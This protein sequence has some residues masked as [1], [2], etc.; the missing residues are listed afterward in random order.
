VSFNPLTALRALRDSPDLSPGEFA[1]MVALVLRSDSGGCMWA[2][3][4]LLAKDCKLSPRSVR[5][6]LQSL[7]AKGLLKRV[8]RPGTSDY[9][10]LDLR[11]LT[12]AESAAP[13]VLT[14]AE[15]AAHPGEIC[16]P[17]R[18]DLPTTPA[19]SAT[20]LPKE[21]PKELPSDLPKKKGPQIKTDSVYVLWGTEWW[22]ELWVEIN[23]ELGRSQP[24]KLTKK[25]KEALK[26][27]LIEHGESVVFDV[28]RWYKKSS[29]P[30]A[31]F[32]RNS[33]YTID[34]VLQRSKFDQYATM[35]ELPEGSITDTNDPLSVLG[36]A[37]KLR[38]EEGQ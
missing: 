20:Y 23:Q 27:R 3:Q 6:K 2:S 24:L 1:V 37:R 5:E 33:G 7:S 16:L 22:T 34:T 11:A 38:L 21:L 17:P 12:L 4:A 32:L 30:R 28:V 13:P 10:V 8:K 18:Q 19:E 9:C 29:H 14:L 35:S 25:R 26:A 31:A 36:A 15:S